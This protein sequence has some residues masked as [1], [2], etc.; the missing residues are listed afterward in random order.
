MPKKRDID[1][2]ALVEMYN[3]G[4]LITELETHFD[5]NHTVIYTH[6]K[7]CGVSANRRAPRKWTAKEDAQLISARNDGCTGQEEYVER[8]PGRSWAA[9]KSRITKMTRT[10]RV[11]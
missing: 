4:T 5:A 3:N 10:G 2:A 11:R 8:M 1:D 6:M 9:I 7:M